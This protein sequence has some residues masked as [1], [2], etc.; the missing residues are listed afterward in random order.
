MTGTE[1]NPG[2]GFREIRRSP[3]HYDEVDF[4]SSHRN[5]TNTFY[6][7]Y[8]HGIPPPPVQSYPKTYLVSTKVSNDVDIENMTIAE[9][10]LYVAKQGLDKN[11]LNNYS[12]GFTPYPH[13]PNTPVD[14]K[15]SDFDKILDDLFRIGADNLKGMGQDIFQ[16]SICKQDVNLEEDWEEDGDDRDTFDMW[17]IMIGDVERIRQFL[18]PNVPEKPLRDFTRPLGSPSGL[19]GLLHTRNSTVIPTKLLQ[20]DAHGVVLGSF[21]AIGR[22]FKFGLVRY[23]A[24]DDDGIFVIMD[25]ARRIRLGA[26]LRACCLFIIPR[27][28]Y[29]PSEGWE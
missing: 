22:H 25:V 15:D 5:K 17:D 9:Y 12:N 18:T 13:T 27:T 26:W 10:N 29:K 2:L 8:S 11:T 28:L 4:S 6:Y 3:T 24:K 16:D 21:F 1:I 19:K 7:P 23:H 14:K 20:V